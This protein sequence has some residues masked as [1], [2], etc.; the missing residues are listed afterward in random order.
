MSK[1]KNKGGEGGWDRVTRYSTTIGTDRL[2]S[3]LGSPFD[4]GS[5]EEPNVT[6]V[7]VSDGPAPATGEGAPLS[8]DQLF[9]ILKNE[10]RR[11]VLRYLHD[12]DGT[13]T[14]GE[15]AETLAAMENDTTVRQI[16]SSQRKRVYVGLYQCHLPK[17]DG[18]D[19]IE[20]EK[21]RGNVA[22][23]PNASLLLPY[24]ME[25]S[26]EAE[27]PLVYG[28]LALGGLVAAFSSLVLAASPVFTT[29]VA[30][31]AIVALFCVSA[32]HLVVSD[33]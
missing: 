7:H 20:F 13:A 32:F 6:E 1:H 28:S 25:D 9:E 27:W 26:D 31:L 30:L 4:R 12:N 14:L 15:L 29:A 3:E 10:R 23:G 22:L 21:N 19:I 8:L 18:M 17:M 2:L 33:D 24:V 11:R 5:D 16:N